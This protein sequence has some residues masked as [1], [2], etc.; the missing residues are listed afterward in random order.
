MRAEIKTS[1]TNICITENKNEYVMKGNIIHMKRKTK[2]ASHKDRRGEM[3][4]SSEILKGRN[5]LGFICV[6]GRTI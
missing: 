4:N 1:E 5:H 3:T 2:C 6:N